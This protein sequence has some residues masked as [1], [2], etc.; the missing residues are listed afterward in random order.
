MTYSC[1][2][3]N[4]FIWFWYDLHGT[5]PDWR[6]FQQNYH[7]VF[8]VQKWNFSKWAE[9]FWWFFWNK[10][11]PRSFVE[12]PEGEGIG[13]KTPGRAW[14]LVRAPVAYTHL[15][16]H[17]CVKPTQNSSIYTRTSKK[18]P[19]SEV[20]PPQASIATRNQSRP[21]SGTLPEGGTITGGHLNHPGGH[22]NEEGVVH[23]WGCGFVP[24]AMCLISL[25]LS[26]SWFGTILM[27]CGL[28]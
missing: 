2:V 26:C 17:L 18:K 22:H 7:G 10:R 9:T 24:V 14:A 3:Y 6:C 13:H 20:L 4:N 11:D 19:R 12:G 1:H 23:P 16:A 27:Y 8:F 21:C 15:E 25:S 5:N 28:C